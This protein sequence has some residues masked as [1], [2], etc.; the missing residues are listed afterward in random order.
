MFLRFALVIGTVSQALL[1][2]DLSPGLFPNQNTGSVRDLNRQA[3]DRQIRSFLSGKPQPPAKNPL[4]PLYPSPLL[5]GRAEV[6]LQSGC[7]IP[8]ERMKIDNT[9][10]YAIKSL[11][12]PKPD[13]DAIAKAPP[14]PACKN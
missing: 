14:L 12:T 4:S 13:F 5:N 9:K 3:L 11:K 7:S 8:L 2:S 6:R 1:A 10:Q